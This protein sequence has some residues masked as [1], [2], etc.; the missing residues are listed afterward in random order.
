MVSLSPQ[1]PVSLVST[2]QGKGWWGG[3]GHPCRSLRFP[4]E[5]VPYSPRDAPLLVTEACV[6]LGPSVVSSISES[7]V[8]RAHA[9]GKDQP[10]AISPTSFAS[11]ALSYGLVNLL[12]ERKEKVS[13]IPHR[14]SSSGTVCFKSAEETSRPQEKHLFAL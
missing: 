4:A 7:R 12:R 8:C 14:A 11:F 9:L 1:G 13:K 10:S 6:P 5:P 2:S 3:K